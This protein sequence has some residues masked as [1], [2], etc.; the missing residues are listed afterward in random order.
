MQITLIIILCILYKK[1]TEWSASLRWGSKTR[2]GRH[3][4]QSKGKKEQLRM[5]IKGDARVRLEQQTQRILS[6]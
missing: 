1:A 4:I 2:I 3:G 6:I 5:E